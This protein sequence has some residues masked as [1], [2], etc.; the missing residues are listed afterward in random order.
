MTL[1]IGGAYQNKYEWTLSKYKE[2][3]IWNDFHLFVK[4][5]L[6]A[7]KTSDEIKQVIESKINSKPGIVI[8]SDEI[9][10]GIIPATKEERTYRE[11]SRKILSRFE[12]R[13]G[14][15]SKIPRRYRRANASGKQT[16][17]CKR[18]ADEQTVFKDFFD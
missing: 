7:G 9:G 3:N 18:F 15:K 16:A 17:F 5:N 4:E 1:I 12:R 8:I 6:A 2:Q 14:R 13:N 11:D 10:C